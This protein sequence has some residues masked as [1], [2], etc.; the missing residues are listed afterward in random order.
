[1]AD[2]KEKNRRGKG[3]GRRGRGGNSPCSSFPSPIF[4]TRLVLTLK[5]EG[6]F[7]KEREKEGGNGPYLYIFNPF[8]GF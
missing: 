7:K 3:E 8:E 1:L 4:P 6:D 2:P 5:K